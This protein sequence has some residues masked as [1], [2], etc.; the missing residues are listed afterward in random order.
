MSNAATLNRLPQSHW[1]NWFASERAYTLLL[2]EGVD[3]GMSVEK[4]AD[5]ACAHVNKVAALWAHPTYKNLSETARKAVLRN[6]IGA[7]L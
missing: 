3:R 2:D 1:N 5:F 4:A 7:N 6:W